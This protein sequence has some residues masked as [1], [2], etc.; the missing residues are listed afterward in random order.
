M[1]TPARLV[2][3]LFCS[4]MVCVSSTPLLS[5][6]EKV[7]ACLSL[8]YF[9]AEKVNAVELEVPKASEA[10]IDVP[11]DD[12]AAPAR[13]VKLEPATPNPVFSVASA[14]CPVLLATLNPK[15][16][17][18]EL[19]AAARPFWVLAVKPRSPAAGRGAADTINWAAAPV[20]VEVRT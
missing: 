11:V 8:P 20:A 10:L 14:W 2:A 17:R 5:V 12:G 16:A 4:A 7:S 6:A 3:R 18:P 15:L 1:L 19:T 9:M 13:A